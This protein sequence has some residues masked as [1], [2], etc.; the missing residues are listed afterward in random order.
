MQANVN[1]PVDL[2]GFR[3][4]MRAAGVEEIVDM[5]VDVYVEEAGRLFAELSSALSQG[6]LDQVRANAHSLK[7]SSG[8]IWAH[9]LAALF[10][11]MEGAAQDQNVGGVQQTYVQLQ[12]EFERVMAY[13]A[14][15]GAGT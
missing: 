2:E 13:L 1:A 11:S 15:A 4:S 9:D 3:A 12:P 8:N 10:A 7:S 14:E 5:T 6:N